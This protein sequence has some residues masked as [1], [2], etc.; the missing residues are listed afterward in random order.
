G[1]S[2]GSLPNESVCPSS[3]SPIDANILSCNNH[4]GWV[5]G[6]A[7]KSSSSSSSPFSATEQRPNLL[8]WEQHPHRHGEEAPPSNTFPKVG[9]GV[10]YPKNR[11]VSRKR[12]TRQFVNENF[13]TSV[14]YSGNY[15]SST[16]SETDS[17]DST[18]APLTSSLLLS[19]SSELLKSDVFR[20]P[21]GSVAAMSN[22]RSMLNGSSSLD[23]SEMMAAASQT[24]GFAFSSSEMK[25]KAIQQRQM[26]ASSSSSSMGGVRASLQQSHSQHAEMIATSSTSRG[27]TDPPLLTTSPLL[28][29]M[30]LS[31]MNMNSSSN[32]GGVTRSF[33]SSSGFHPSSSSSNTLFSDKNGSEDSAIQSLG[34]LTTDVVPSLESFVSPFRRAPFNFRNFNR[35]LWTDMRDNHNRMTWDPAILKSSTSS[36]QFSA[37]KQTFFEASTVNGQL[38]SVKAFKDQRVMLRQS[39][40]ASESESDNDED[41]DDDDFK[42]MRSITYRQKPALPFQPKLAIMNKPQSYIVSEDDDDRSSVAPSELES[43]PRES[44]VIEELPVTPEHKKCYK[45]ANE[46]LTT[47]RTYVKILHLL[48]QIFHF[49]VDQE[50]RVQTMFTPEIITQ[51]FCNIKSLYQLH[52]DHLLPQLEKRLANWEDDPRIGDIMKDFAPFLKMYSEYVQNFDNS[53]NLINLY[54]EKNVRFMNIIND[55]QK[56]EECCNLPIQHHLIG[57]IQRIPRYRLLLEAYLRRLPEDSDD[58]PDTEK[59]LE[60]VSKAAEHANE[61]MRRIASFKKLLEVQENVKGVVDLVSP[62][63][64]LVKEGKI[65]KISAR[66]GDHQERYV[67][68][69]S[70]VMLLCSIR[71]IANR[72]ISN[73]PYQL[74]ARLDVASITVAEGDDLEV[75]NTFYVEDSHKKIEL[76]TQKGGLDDSRPQRQGRA[77]RAQILPRLGSISP[78]EDELGTKEPTKLKSDSVSKCMECYTSFSIMKRRHHCHACGS[79]V[80][81]K[82][83]DSKLPLQYAGGKS[84]RVCKR[85]KTVLLEKEAQSK[86]GG[87]T[88]SDPTTPE[89]SAERLRG[90]LD[91][92]AKVPAV[93]SGYLS[94]R[95]RGRKEWTTRW[96]AL[97]TDFVLYCYDK[98]TD[99]RAMTATPIPGMSTLLLEELPKGDCPNV[100]PLEK[101]RVFRIAHGHGRKSFVF[102]APSRGDALNWISH[103]KQAAK[104]ELNAANNNN[105]TS[106][107]DSTTKMRH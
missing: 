89:D 41:D 78:T 70:D 37:S 28:S 88:D 36:I 98:E 2:C 104:A 100:T 68:L 62:T 25:A 96:F 44:V 7:Q 58:R 32:F 27:T 11:L 74:R 12:Y 79:V 80:C 76:Y 22:F 15:S 8:E 40:G 39:Y 14:V 50:N 59:A 45:V 83:S 84:C 20:L 86:K 69:F 18:A 3:S 48:D 4:H 66:T 13:T 6:G 101:E 77:N 60:I 29:S 65:S 81:A 5:D 10:N 23:S 56:M 94:L 9:S 24:Q 34:Q 49:R 17:V 51:M 57:P 64:T 103:L 107:T 38:A 35:P 93:L 42:G 1:G 21:F 95:L 106:A 55:I 92:P 82:C 99:E 43:E 91:V 53:I 72:M 19:S 63:R 31:N 102:L 85:C 46:L 61:A 67:F 75:V 26:F 33:S 90:V 52:H 105:A 30:M 16:M 97:R 54:R 87:G 47:E 73:A 71:P